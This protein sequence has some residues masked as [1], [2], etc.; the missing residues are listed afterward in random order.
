M[1]SNIIV[2]NNSDDA[3]VEVDTIPGG[4]S[5]DGIFYKTV[6]GKHY[7]IANDGAIR[8]VKAG[9]LFDGTDQTARINTILAHADV[10]E[11]FFD[12]YNKSITISG[13]VTV[14]AGKKLIFKNKCKLVGAGTVSGGIV[15]CDL[16]KQCFATTL[17]VQNLDNSLV[18]VMWFGAVA[19]FLIGNLYSQTKTD[20]L[21]AFTK[22]LS[23]VRN[24]AT[25]VAYRAASRIFIPPTQ[26]VDHAYYLSNTWVVDRGVEIFGD[27]MDTTLLMFPHGVVGIHV[28]S[29]DSGD[30]TSRGG[31]NAFLRDFTV[32]GNSSK[33]DWTWDD[34]T[35]FGILV[36]QNRAHLA[37]IAVNGFGSN[38]IYVYAHVPESNANNCFIEDCVGYYNGGF[39]LKFYSTDANKCVVLKGDFSYNVRGGVWEN[40]FLGNS[41]Y[42]I[43]T[44]S[45][46][47][48]SQYNRS[49]VHYL[50]NRFICKKDDTI[51]V[52]PPATAV[53]S[54]K[55]WFAGVGGSLG[56]YIRDYDAGTTYMEGPAFRW[57]DANQGGVWSAL[58]AEGDQ[59]AG[60]AYGTNVIVINS[61][62]TIEGQSLWKTDGHLRVPNLLANETTFGG[63]MP[64]LDGPS[65]Y[66]GWT[67]QTR[68]GTL[69]GFKYYGDVNIWRVNSANDDNTNASFFGYGAPAS[70]FGRSATPIPSIAFGALWL[71]KELNAYG[72]FRMLGF[73]TAAPNGTTFAGKQFAIGDLL[74]NVGTDNTI[75]AW[76]CSTAGTYGGSAPVF[77]AISVGTGGGGSGTVNSGTANR[78]SYYGTTGTAVSQLAAITINRVLIS[79]ANGLP[80]ASAVTVTALGY[81]DAT[82]S[83]QTQIDAKQAILVSATNIKT[84][85]GSS[86]LGSGDLPI[87][88]SLTTNQLGYGVSGSLGSSA[89][90]TYDGTTMTLIGS[91]STGNVLNIQQ[92]AGGGSGT[93][94]ALAFIHSNTSLKM[95]FWLD[96]GGA[97]LNVGT[98]YEGTPVWKIFR[99]TGNMVI[100]GTNDIGY[101]TAIFGGGT[102]NG[103]TGGLLVEYSAFLATGFGGV[104]IGDTTTPTALLHI[105]AGTATTGPLKLTAGTNVSTIA[106]G[107]QDGLME[108]D[109]THLSFII[110]STRYQLDQQAVGSNS[111]IVVNDAD[112]TIAAGVTDVVVKAQTTTR[113]ITL[114]SAASSTNRK[115]TIR[116]ATA[117]TCSLSIAIRDSASTTTTSLGTNAWATIISDGTDWWIVAQ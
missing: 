39:G 16:Q 94:P 104:Y 82:S 113:T 22:A 97:D 47:V 111:L 2:A 53:S 8:A 98:V 27:Q 86:I 96:N 20:N 106:A 54:D 100:K 90:G 37:R 18:S 30:I 49:F 62:P 88:A 50:G 25:Y 23:S 45:N 81:L 74:L 11:L 92:V 61:T 70:W 66:V 9:V 80:I 71:G 69:Q 12:A 33:V 26:D 64:T 1:A 63:W 101:R 87:S 107:V 32:W 52:T 13:T 29:V 65:R 17:T 57:G 73:A 95:F 31:S 77:D 41:A 115:I 108:Y 55:W 42:D 5:N 44:A 99:G 89:N 36:Q 56:T 59:W 3:F 93:S 15:E 21:S 48:L 7:K 112:Y 85:N 79:D 35:S 78:L 84:I 117:T 75:I 105:K 67:D 46:V 114:P 102:A 91:G 58:Y 60:N 109:G 4:Y 24:R 28:K 110:G 68:A 38:G 14:P 72:E 83:I 43:H 116:N 6:S 40:S 10:H 76:K 103:N 34:D 51:G 19:D